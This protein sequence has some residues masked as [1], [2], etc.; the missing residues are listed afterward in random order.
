MDLK[1]YQRDKKRN[2]EPKN[3]R[4]NLKTTQKVSEWMTKNNISPQKV[5]DESISKLVEND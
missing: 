3:V 5:W 4:I 1:K 2:T